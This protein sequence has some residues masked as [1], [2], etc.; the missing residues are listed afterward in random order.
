MTRDINTS[1]GNVTITG[2]NFIESDSIVTIVRYAFENYNT[3]EEIDAYIFKNFG[4]H[5]RNVF[6]DE[7]KVIFES[8]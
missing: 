8:Y 7:R 6:V 1:V 4:Q 2:V 5:P 3:A